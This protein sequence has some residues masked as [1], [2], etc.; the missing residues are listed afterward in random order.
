M[1]SPAPRCWPSRE[2][3]IAQVVA[4]LNIGGPAVH[5]VMLAGRFN[6]G[7][8]RS[9]LIYGTPLEDEGDM[10]YLLEGGEVEAQAVPA[11]S[12]EVS[13]AG[14]ARAFAGV[15]GVFRR[16]RPHIVHTHAAKAGF[17]GRA[18]AAASGIRSCVHTFHGHTFAHYFGRAKTRA[19]L[20]VERSLAH[21]TSRIIAVTRQQV[22]DLVKV[23]RVAGAGKVVCIPH[24]LD[25]STFLR[26]E[27]ARTVLRSR[28]GIGDDEP[29]VGIAGRLYPIKGHD[30]F[31]Q[32]AAR[33]LR[34]REKVHFL[35]VGDGAERPRLEE[36][37]RRLRIDA[38][39]HFVGWQRDMAGAYAAMD[40]VALT[41]LNE[42][43]PLALIE[44]MAS[45]RPAVSTSAGGVP[46][47]FVEPRRA[48]KLRVALNGILVDERDPALFA[49]ALEMLLADRELRDGMGAQARRFARENFSEER[50]FDRIERLYLGLVP[51]S[52]PREIAAYQAKG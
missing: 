48:G 29:V 22:D 2:V 6:E 49:E 24:G 37:A 46:D 50:M 41:S 30:L 39:V 8:Y 42:G 7:N 38:N 14:D 51:W 18:A 45:G 47:L 34:R 4:R 19:F 40:V 10:S 35:I 25:L 27:G 13:V 9:L 11:L 5:T 3:R 36:E 20:A 17:I 52:A 15:A 44:G 28:L 23:Y 33:L 32:S 43:S 12:R 16:F 31:I 1:N 21:L 26:C